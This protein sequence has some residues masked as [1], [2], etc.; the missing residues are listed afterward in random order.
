MLWPADALVGVRPLFD[1]ASGADANGMARFELTRVGVDG[2]PQS[3]KGLKAT[4]VREL[5]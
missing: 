1:V 5:R 3:A 2:K 4:L